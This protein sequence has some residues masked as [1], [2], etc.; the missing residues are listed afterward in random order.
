ME[1]LLFLL[2]D[3]NKSSTFCRIAEAL[4]ISLNSTQGESQPSKYFSLVLEF[5]NDAVVVDDEEEVT[6][7]RNL[8]ASFE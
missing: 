6:S 5:V 4:K 2:R 7:S 8:R 3:M 1:E